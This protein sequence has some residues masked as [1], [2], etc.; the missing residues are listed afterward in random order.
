MNICI[1]KE[2]FGN[3]FFISPKSVSA[4]V[5]EGHKV[6]FHK[7]AFQDSGY[8]QSEFEAAGAI[9]A[10]STREMLLSSNIIL[11]FKIPSIEVIKLLKEGQVIIS[12]SN[13]IKNR[14]KANLLASKKI[15][16]VDVNFFSNDK[17]NI[18]D[19][20]DNFSLDI[21]IVYIKYFFSNIKT[22]TNN[23][24][25][26]INE[27]KINKK[28]NIV[29]FGD[30]FDYFV[31]IFK[32]NN[33][34][35][36]GNYSCFYNNSNFK[37]IELFDKSDRKCLMSKLK[38]ADLIV[39]GYRYGLS[40]QNCLIDSPMFDMIKENS[41]LVDLSMNIGGSFAH[42]RET[43]LKSPFF[44]KDSKFLFCP[45]DI[46]EGYGK[47]FSDY[48]EVY[49]FPFLKQI[50]N[51]EV[52]LSKQPYSIVRNGDIMDDIEFIDR[53]RNSLLIKEPFDVMGISI[54]TDMI[55]KSQINKRLDN[56]YDHDNWFQ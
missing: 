54:S 28:I 55:E 39:S 49:I 14:K 22:R 9:E 24:P 12:N 33:I 53:R 45:S 46:F 31:D 34:S 29:Y 35:V 21:S 7:N 27:H 44:S 6:V 43:N 38:D 48:L 8:L 47:V 36:F 40:P 17:I 1:L 25:S 3:K 4:L 10:P 41:L 16:L 5:K 15:T 42:S 37:N 51:R 13:I 52:D 56:V 20:I 19:I 2:S 11:S 32:G 23:L 18:G 30:N 26:L 50:V